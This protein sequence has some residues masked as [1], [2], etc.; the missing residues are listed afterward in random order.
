MPAIT[1][2]TLL[3]SALGAA[4]LTGAATRNAPGAAAV[5][6]PSIIGT[7]TWGAEPAREPITMVGPPRTIVVHHT[8]S[9]NVTDV[10]QQAAYDIARQ[11]QQWHFARGWADTG[12][13]FT[14]S[15]GGFVLEG[16][17]RTLEGLD[18][19]QRQFPLGAHSLSQ[20]RTALGI[21]N[22]GTYTSALPPAAQWQSLVRLC[23]F[24][25]QTY[26]L[27]PS[28]IQGHRTFDS[29]DCPGDA[30]FAELPRLR[31]DVAALLGGGGGTT[32]RPW[33]VLRPGAT[34]FRVTCAQ[35][36]LRQA[37]HEAPTGGVFDD[38]TTAAV[39]A[40][41]TSRSLDPDGVVGRLTWEVPLAL[42]RRNGDRGEGVRAVQ[43]AL[44]AR[45]ASVTV[46]GIF[47]SSTQ[48]AVE[49]FQDAQGLTV[50]GVVGLDTWSRLLA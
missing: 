46:D 26:A 47:G 19:G 21:E 2:R 50:D 45:G 48:A 49:R 9:A 1:R 5:E 44:T 41:Q 17:H 16:R 34:G 29:T 30:F 7:A 13:H 18:G 42:T 14:V 11:I 32:Q 39:K 24:L 12:Q 23:A 28:A 36:L 22:Q 15:R 35:R 31:T 25:C 27:A 6:R 8:A 4:A 3:G 40:F 10:S 33:P 20:N 43:T 38:P 37:G